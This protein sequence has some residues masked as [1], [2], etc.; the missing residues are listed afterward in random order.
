MN[1]NQIA[2]APSRSALTEL[3]VG[4]CRQRSALV[5]ITLMIG[6]WPRIWL[7]MRVSFHEDPL[8]K[9]L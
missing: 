9:V 4:L 7:Y 2:F 1:Q 8:V 5:L 3:S 6:V